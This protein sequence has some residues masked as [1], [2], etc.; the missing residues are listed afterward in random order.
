VRPGALVIPRLEFLM[1]IAK[2]RARKER[3]APQLWVS[4]ARRRVEAVV[5]VKRSG[6]RAHAAI[7]RQFAAG[8]PTK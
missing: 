8:S 5:V 3:T 2:R 7:R 1:F 4:D 6:N